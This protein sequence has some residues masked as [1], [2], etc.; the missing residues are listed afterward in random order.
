[1]HLQETKITKNWIFNR[2]NVSTDQGGKRQTN[3][4]NQYFIQSR[5]R[6]LKILEKYSFTHTM[7]QRMKL[8]YV[9]SS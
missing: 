1:M 8:E 4:S 9:F 2:I 6:C 5:F 3:S 7:S